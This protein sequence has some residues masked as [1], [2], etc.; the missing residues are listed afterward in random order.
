MGEEN[1]RNDVALRFLSNPA[2]TW[3]FYAGSI[4]PVVGTLRSRALIPPRHARK[5]ELPARSAPSAEP[6]RRKCIGAALAR[7]SMTGV[8]TLDLPSGPSDSMGAPRARS[9]FGASNGTE[10]GFGVS[11]GRKNRCQFGFRVKK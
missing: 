6:N 5:H 11:F 9:R 1:I 2:L 10:Q 4:G 8:S 7:L 3:M